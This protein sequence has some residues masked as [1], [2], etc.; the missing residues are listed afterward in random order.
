[1]ANYRYFFQSHSERSG[2]PQAP[3]MVLDSVRWLLKDAKEADK[4]SGHEQREN[5]RLSHIDLV[6]RWFGVIDE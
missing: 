3:D 6:A 4:E 5:W 2:T 1:M